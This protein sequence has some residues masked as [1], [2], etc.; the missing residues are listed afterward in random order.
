M[1]EHME[2]TNRKFDDYLTEIAKC[3]D[4]TKI[5]YFLDSINNEIISSHKMEKHYISNKDILMLKELTTYT[6][7]WNMIVIMKSI[8]GLILS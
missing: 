2:D 6:L 1:L 4:Y 8:N 7:T 5:Y 3:D